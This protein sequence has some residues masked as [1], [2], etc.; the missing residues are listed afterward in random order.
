[1]EPQTFHRYVTRNSKKS[2]LRLF[3]GSSSR[4]DP[5]LIDITPSA[6]SQGP[7]S[8]KRKQN[9][10]VPYDVIEIDGDE[11]PSGVVIIGNEDGVNGKKKMVGHNKNKQKQIK[12]A[13]AEDIIA[14]ANHGLA[15]SPS[16]NPHKTLGLE[17]QNLNYTGKFNPDFMDVEDAISFTLGPQFSLNQPTW[18]EDSIP[19][20]QKP[21]YLQPLTSSLTP[22]TQSSSCKQQLGNEDEIAKKFGLFKQFDTVRDH[23]DHQYNSNRGS[24]HGVSLTKKAPLQ[25]SKK[26]QQEWKILREDLPESIFVRVYEERMDLLRAVIVGAAGTPYHDGLFFFDIF[27]PSSYPNQPPL[28]HYYS[29]GLRLNPNLYECGK[30]CLSLL[31]TWSGSKSELWTPGKSTIL[32]VLLSIQALVLNAKPFFNEPGYASMAGSLE[33]EKRSIAYNEQAFLL[34]CRT[35][36]Y[37]LQRPLKNFEDFIAGHFFQHAHSILEACKAYMDG[38]QVGCLVGGGVQDV[39]E[40]DKSC[41]SSFRQQLGQLYPMLLKAF[42]DKGAD[43]TPFLCQSGKQS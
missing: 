9:Q 20:L 25:W 8:S 42:S 29:G 15:T 19:P 30:V 2:D 12:D 37:T 33:G 14:Y 24:F 22:P 5:E 18:V 4:N 27:F 17:S 34:S 11:D 38:A 23:S 40:G 39:D 10:V 1:M 7:R 35:M 43:C 28:V 6:S 16:W 32:Q 26:I 3:S 13:F 41:S 21:A 36:L 31:N